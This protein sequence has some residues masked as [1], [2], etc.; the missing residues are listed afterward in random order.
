MERLDRHDFNINNDEILAFSTIRNEIL[1]LPWFLQF[2]RNLGISRFFIVDNGS[3]DGST[4]YLLSQNNV[5]LFYTTE[6]YADANVGMNWMNSLLVTYA[7]GKWTLTIDADELFIFPGFENV[8]LKRLVEFLDNYGYD[9]LRAPLIDMYS[10]KS[11]KDTDYQSGTDFLATC[12]YFD[13][14]AMTS[15]FRDGPRKRLFWNNTE[16]D[17]NPPVLLKFPLVKW[18]KDRFFKASTHVIEDVNVANIS[19]VLLH[20]KM[21]SDFFEKVTVAVE[22][23]EHWQGAGQYAVYLAGIQKNPV[24][25]PYYDGSVRFEN[26]DQ[27][28]EMGLMQDSQDFRDF[29]KKRILT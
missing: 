16:R 7:P 24:I 3:A 11:I 27:L 1:R 4:E 28:V 10:A 13:S 9:S 23:G 18:Q 14:E 5:H 12:P 8:S 15:D 6:S 22:E 19:G 25:S 2:Y 26:S 20:F 21:F 29:R 17:A